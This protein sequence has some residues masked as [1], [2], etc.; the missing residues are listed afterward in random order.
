LFQSNGG[1]I[2]NDD[3]IGIL[4]NIEHISQGKGRVA[5]RRDFRTSLLSPINGLRTLGSP[6][7][8]H[9]LAV[10]KEQKERFG[11]ERLWRL[12]QVRRYR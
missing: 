12:D 6:S 10:K 11:Q 8:R 5:I 7:T 2:P 3:A 1:D 4:R 9:A